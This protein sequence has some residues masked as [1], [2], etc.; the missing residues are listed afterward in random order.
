MYSDLNLI[1]HNVCVCA[2]R[3]AASL[4]TPLFPVDPTT[5]P[6]QKLKA[7][8]IFDYQIYF[9]EP[10][11]LQHTHAHTHTHTHTHTYTLGLLEN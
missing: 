5:D 11:S 1:E 3:A 9:Q 4:N 6:M 8:P 10:V 7:F 2:R